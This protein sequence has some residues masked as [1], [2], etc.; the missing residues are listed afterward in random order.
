MMLAFT[1]TAPNNFSKNGFIRNNTAYRNIS[2]IAVSAGI[3]LDGSRNVLVENNESYNN[4]TGISI[5]NE[6]PNSI[7]GYHVINSNVFR[8]N[9]TAGL[10]YGSTNT[11]SWVE[12]C[13]VKNNTI[14]NNFIIDPVL[15]ARANNM[16]G[17]SNAADR[18][19][20]VNIYRVAQQ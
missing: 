9:L 16:Y 6:Q 4:G 14:K 10:Y 8:D 3:Y 2:P 1:V 18:Y 11:T 5:G 20:E 7:S 19:P 17:I 15:R 12:R 13:N